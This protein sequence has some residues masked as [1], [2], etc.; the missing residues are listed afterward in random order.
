MQPFITLPAADA[1]AVGRVGQD[2]D[3]RIAAKLAR[4]FA[5]LARSGNAG[6][7][8]DAVEAG[9]E[10]DA[11]LV[12]AGGRGMPATETLA[13]G[14]KKDGDA[15]RAALTTPWSNGQTEGQ[16]NRLMLAKR[17]TCGHASFDLLRRRVLLAA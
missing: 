14:L 9:A 4:G 5:A 13:A 6:T 15:T 3:A 17:Q 11:W 8:T 1:A 12:E 7:Q 16:A 2:K 10:L